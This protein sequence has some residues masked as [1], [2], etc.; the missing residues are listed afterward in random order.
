MANSDDFK[1]YIL[2]NAIVRNYEDIRDALEIDE[3]FIRDLIKEGVLSEKAGIDYINNIQQRSKKKNIKS[4]LMKEIL[5][6]N[7]VNVVQNFVNILEKKPLL[8]QYIDHGIYDAEADLYNGALQMSFETF[9]QYVRFNGSTLILHLVSECVLNIDE[10]ELIDIKPT[11]VSKCTELFQI[12][13][14]KG[15]K[16]PTVVAVLRKCGNDRVAEEILTNLTKSSQVLDQKTK[17]TLQDKI[18]LGL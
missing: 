8:K 10:M 4:V 11:Q 2:K 17:R 3:T 12:L 15:D 1:L 7:N 13:L 18:F 5:N 16:L 6:S 14:R 9:S